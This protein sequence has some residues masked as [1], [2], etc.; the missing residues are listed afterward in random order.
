MLFYESAL[1]EGTGVRQQGQSGW[2]ASQGRTQSEWYLWEHGSRVTFF[3]S[4]LAVATSSRHT[5]HTSTL[6]AVLLSANLGLEFPF[7]ATTL[8]LVLFVATGGGGGGL[9][10]STPP[11]SRSK[12]LLVR[13][14][15]IIFSRL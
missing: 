7:P 3:C 14:N 4:L 15:Q 6:D 1:R 5:A 12:N 9:E 10:L 2:L 13:L 11:P 8:W